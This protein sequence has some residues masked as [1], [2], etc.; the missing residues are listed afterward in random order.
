LS[1]THAHPLSASPEEAGIIAA[2]QAHCQAVARQRARN[3]FY[4]MRLTPEPK[5]SAVY[6]VYAW[7]RQADDLADAAGEDDAKI[8]ALEAFRRD[9]HLVCQPGGFEAA[10]ELGAPFW[11]ALRDAVVRYDIPAEYLD[12][13][14]DGQILDQHKTRYRTF[15]ELYDYCY[16]VASV[17]GLTC[18]EVWGYVGGERTRE[19]SEWR[20]IAFQL[21]NILRDLVEDAQ[22]DRVYL[23][24]EDCGLFELNPSM[25]T[26]APQPDVI[27]GVRRVAE[28]ARGY[29]EASAELEHHVHDDGLAC[30]W[31]MTRIYRGLLDKIEA[32]PQRVITGSRVRLSSWRKA[33]IAL[34]ARL[35]IG[36]DR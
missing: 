26:L 4:G 30:L 1:G 17:V 36:I 28:R 21:T 29:Y 9:T 33:V 7:M 25:F 15:E 22:R 14:I 2:S 5:R 6:A 24:A 35:R 34:R 32:D 23:P 13:M 8:A 27:E 12:A 10:I 20:G 31:A 11:P 3:F 19:L 16:K 18:I